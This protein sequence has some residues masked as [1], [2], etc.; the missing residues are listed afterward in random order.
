M[1]FLKYI[2]DILI[3]VCP[4]NIH[5]HHSEEAEDAVDT[6]FFETYFDNNNNMEREYLRVFN[7]SNNHPKFQSRSFNF[8]WTFID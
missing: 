6:T 7:F 2:S 4:T 5:G 3:N 8:S 1:F